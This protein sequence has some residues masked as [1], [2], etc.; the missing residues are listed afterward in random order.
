MSPSRL[1]QYE[2]T[3]VPLAS[4]LYNVISGLQINLSNSENVRDKKHIRTPSLHGTHKCIAG[5]ARHICTIVPEKAAVCISV[6]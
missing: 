5:C 2:P 6:D 1:L 3:T 4:Y